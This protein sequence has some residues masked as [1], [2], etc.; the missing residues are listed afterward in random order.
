MPGA[1]RNM[2]L[3]AFIGTAV[4]LIAVTLLT[5]VVRS[6]YTHSNLNLGFD[7][8]YTRT[9]QMVVGPP[10]PFG[11]GELAVPRASDPVQLGKQLFVVDGCASCHGLD[12]RGGI[13]APSVV[14]T[15]AEKLRVKTQ[16]GPQGMPAY[17]PGALTDA[18]LAA[19]A[20]YLD[21]MSK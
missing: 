16:V 12:G 18:D 2:L 4:L 21:A 13:A 20:A 14:G 15:K 11:A 5:I 1:T 19:M 9:E 17:A 10:V 6:P 7:P 3:P 8:G